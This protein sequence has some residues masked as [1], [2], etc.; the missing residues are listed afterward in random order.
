MTDAARWNLQ[1]GVPEDRSQ[2][3]TDYTPTSDLDMWILQHMKMRTLANEL[4]QK[5]QLQELEK[6]AAKQLEKE[7]E[8][9]IDEELDKLLKD[10]K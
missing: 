3:W 5:R 6:A 9:K 2:E 8:K 10:F 1:H 4:Q 7:L